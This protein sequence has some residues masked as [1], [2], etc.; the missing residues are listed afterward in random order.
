M[1]FFSNLF[2]SKYDKLTREDIVQAIC[3]LE[4]QQKEIEDSMEADKKKKDELLA[5]G[6][7]EK[8]KN[9]K[10]LYAKKINAIDASS[11]RNIER[12]MYLN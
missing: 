2:K 12:A 7:A 3:E 1:G 10:L 6:R 9:M 5:K 4:T 8:D 11:K